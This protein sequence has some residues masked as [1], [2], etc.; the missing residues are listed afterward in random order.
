MIRVFKFGQHAHRTP[1]SYVALRNYFSG[2]VRL[3]ERID[4]ADIIVFS[5][6]LDVERSPHFLIEDWRRSGKPIV[7]L[8]EEPFWD[9]IW[10][11]RPLDPLIY[12]ET[13][14]GTLPVVQINH[15]IGT[16]FEFAH[17]P[18]YILTNYRFQKAYK[19]MFQRNARKRA[20]DWLRDWSTRALD[21]SFMFERRPEPYHWVEWPPANLIGLCSWR[22][23]FAQCCRVLNVERLG[24]SWGGEVSRFELE[25]DWHADKLHRLDGRSRMLG[26]IE[27]THQPRYITEKIFDAFS[28]GSL[29]IYY[30]NPSHKIHGYKLPTESWIN[31]SGLSPEEASDQLSEHSFDNNVAQAY[32]ESQQ[33]LLALSSNDELWHEERKRL[34]RAT[35]EALK[36]V[37]K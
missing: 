14:Y 15:Q 11:K 2:T 26:A 35:T 34:A 22:T 20:S 27:N 33:M 8:S 13:K 4:Q 21:V 16:V 12:V 10:G 24:K 3:V 25:T 7:I 6:I 18:Y 29:P 19:R 9:T 23:E 17:V 5:H 28:C 31:V 37:C 30:A 1:L 36:A 32:V